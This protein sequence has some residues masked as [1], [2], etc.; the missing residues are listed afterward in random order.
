MEMAGGHQASAARRA[1][2]NG[3]LTATLNENGTLNVN[4]A[5]EGTESIIVWATQ[6]G[7]TQY[8]K[9]N[10]RADFSTSVNEL[11]AHR[12]VKDVTYYNASGMKSD[13]PFDG[14]NIV[15]TRFNDGSQSTAKIIR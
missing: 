13:K 5:S 9:L 12:G 15:V 11:S 2:G 4:A 1:E 7:Q 3:I 8:V 14:V 6:K 10:L